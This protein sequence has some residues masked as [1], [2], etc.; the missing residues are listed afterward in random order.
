MLLLIPIGRG[1]WLPTAGW[2]SINLG[3]VG[4]PPRDAGLRAD[5]TASCRGPLLAFFLAWLGPDAVRTMWGV[6]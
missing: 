4:A 1:R 2:L 6:R 5:S 3:S